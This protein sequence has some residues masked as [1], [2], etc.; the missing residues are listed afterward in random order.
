[1]K[2]TERRLI[3]ASHRIKLLPKCLKSL[4][5]DSLSHIAHKRE[6]VVEIVDRSKSKVGEFSCTKEVSQV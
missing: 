1:M 4:L 3:S 5:Q 6:I 2:R